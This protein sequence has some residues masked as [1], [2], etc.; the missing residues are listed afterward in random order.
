MTCQVCGTD[1][2]RLLTVPATT[3]TAG[4]LRLP[5]EA[6]EA[7]RAEPPAGYGFLPVELC[8]ACFLPA[9]DLAVKATTLAAR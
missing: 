3:A 8:A 6:L 1:D 2:P 7:L 5:D 9:Y 4:L